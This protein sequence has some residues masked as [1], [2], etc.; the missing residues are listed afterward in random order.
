MDD[1]RRARVQE[2]ESLE[3]LATP[4]LQNLVVDLLEPFQV[5]ES[6]VNGNLCK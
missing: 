3:D 5:P 1:G 6:N 4:V 2:V